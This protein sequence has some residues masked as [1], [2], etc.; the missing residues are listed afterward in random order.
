MRK[1]SIAFLLAIA[2]ALPGLAAAQS[3]A[4]VVGSAPGKAGVAQTV[5]VTA[6]IAA[7]DKAT[8][9]VTLKGRQGNEIVVTAGSEVKNFD[10]M[11]VGDQVNAQYVEALTVE[12]KKGGGMTVA[13]ATKAA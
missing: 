1:L 10:N 2:S 5:Q 3:G 4:A 6:T 13:Q 12:L 8:R 9:D 7:I 11:K